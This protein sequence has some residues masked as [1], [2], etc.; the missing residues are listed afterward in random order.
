MVC[1]LNTHTCARRRL[2]LVCVRGC[3][4]GGLIL[5]QEKKNNNKKNT[6][7]Q[8][9]D[10]R[11]LVRLLLKGLRNDALTFYDIQNAHREG[12]PAVKD[13]EASYQNAGTWWH[14]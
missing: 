3:R 8:K 1:V 9:L 7:K 2:Q 5:P 6:D 13:K 4:V 12:D 14:L 11:L 10:C